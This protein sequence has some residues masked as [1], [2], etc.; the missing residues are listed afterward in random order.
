MH[1][2]RIW[3]GFGLALLLCVAAS[4]TAKAQGLDS[5][6]AAFARGDYTAAIDLWNEAAAAAQANGDASIRADAL[7]RRAEAYQALGFLRQAEDD[8][9]L[10]LALTDGES[11]P[12]RVIHFKGMLGSVRTQIGDIDEAR[13]DLGESLTLADRRGE[14]E[15]AAVTLNNIGNF[16][17]LERRYLE[18]TAVYS[19]SAADAQALGLPDLA[20]IAA[21]NAAA[22]YIK[23]EDAATAGRTLAPVDGRLS[24]SPISARR[25][26]GRIKLGRLHGDL[27][28]LGGERSGEA[29][30]TAYGN[31]RA[32]HEGAR[33]LNNPWLESQALGYLGGLYE[34]RGRLTEALDLTR[35][36]IFL[37]QSVGAPES[38]FLW[39]WQ[40]GRILR[41]AGDH[42]GAITAHKEAIKTLS[43]VR[44]DIIAA[45]GNGRDLFDQAVRPLIVGLADLLLQSANVS[46]GNDQQALLREARQ[47]V[48][49]LKAAE[50]EDYFH[51]DCLAALQAKQQD[52][53][54]L[55]PYTAALYPV[56]L[57]D[58][59]ELLV[60]GAG[61]LERIVVAKG[62]AEIEQEVQSFRRTVT[63][64]GSEAYRLHA[65]RL[66]DWLIAPIESR[67]EAAGAKTLIVIPVG[68][69]AAIPFAALRDADGFL[70]EKFAVAV[71]PGLS[72]VDPRPFSVPGAQA[73]VGG[74]SQPVENFAALPHVSDELA[75][76]SAVFPSSVLHDEEFVRAGLE[77]ALADVPYRVVHMATH[78]QFEAESADSFLLT[79]DGRLDMDDLEALVKLSQFRDEPVELLTLSACATALGDPRAALGLAG[80]GIKAGAR[81]AL[82]SL[83]L[84]NDRSTAELVTRFYRALAEPGTSKAEALRRA[85]LALLSQPNFRHPLY[86]APF[87]IVGNWL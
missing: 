2:D 83:W 20:W 32:A 70:V 43:A 18:A 48:E 73:L 24:A 28:R 26:N 33:T 77:D 76:V 9:I 21:L 66:H 59:L 16:L 84:V 69:L 29:W 31:L 7:A 74:L 68:S 1:R 49:L 72:L 55:P 78:A 81:S 41:S 54:A 58:R 8:L 6:D 40:L 82:A 85:Q 15:L 3:R 64:T 50:I 87:L 52:I 60:T 80:L 10:A 5:G 47:T 34:S 57:P 35:R 36:A 86:W 51:D 75:A 23:L 38:L 67:L 56:V 42:P 4:A 19:E 12:V 79:Y 37:A 27:A 65:A 22:A 14:R 13:A 17:L 46:E 44:G 25:I 62:E 53:D 71:A 39:Q 11:T 61:G 63:E 30:R 45:F